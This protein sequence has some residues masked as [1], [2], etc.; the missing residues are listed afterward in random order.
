MSFNN[1]VGNVVTAGGTMGT[2]S[3]WGTAV[4]G[5]GRSLYAGVRYSF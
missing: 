5:P 4:P 3:S 2:A 1:S